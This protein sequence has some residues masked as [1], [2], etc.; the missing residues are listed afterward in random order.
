MQVILVKAQDSAWLTAP[1]ILNCPISQIKDIRP[2]ATTK[3]M[4]TAE[5][6]RGYV[7]H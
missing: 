4:L 2:K 5:Q 3:A 1:Q 6:I 7:K